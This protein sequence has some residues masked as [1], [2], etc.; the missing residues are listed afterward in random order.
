MRLPN[1]EIIFVGNALVRSVKNNFDDKKRNEQVRSLLTQK[2]EVIDKQ[3]PML[4]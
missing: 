2:I 3:L 1:T 4:I